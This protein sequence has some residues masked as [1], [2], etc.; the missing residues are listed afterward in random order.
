MGSYLAGLFG[1]PNVF[2][3]LLSVRWIQLE[4]VLSGKEIRGFILRD[5]K[6]FIDTNKIEISVEYDATGTGI[7]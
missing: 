5:C 2:K 6:S 3:Q 7:L 1:I 4:V